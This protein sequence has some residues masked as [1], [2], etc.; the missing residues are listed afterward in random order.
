MW[1]QHYSANSNSSFELDFLGEGASA[2][3]VNPSSVVPFLCS[4]RRLEVEETK[5]SETEE[6]SKVSVIDTISEVGRILSLYRFK[7]FKKSCLIS[8]T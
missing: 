8:V 3:M 1:T 7:W 4:R 2:L 5:S 6:Y